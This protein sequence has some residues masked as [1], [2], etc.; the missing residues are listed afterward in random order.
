MGGY[1]NIQREKSE[2]AVKARKSLG[3]MPN[4]RHLIAPTCVRADLGH[5]VSSRAS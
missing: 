5:F 4:R 1:E 3:T 2:A